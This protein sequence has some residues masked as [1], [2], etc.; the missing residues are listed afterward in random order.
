MKSKQLTFSVASLVLLCV[1]TYCKAGWFTLDPPNSTETELNDIAGDRIDGR[2]KHEDGKYYGC[3]YDGIS[4]TTLCYPGAI[5]TAANGVDGDKIVGMYANTPN[6]AYHGFICDYTNPEEPKWTPIDMDSSMTVVRGIDGVNKVGT[7]WSSG[8]SSGFSYDGSTWEIIP[9]PTGSL[10]GGATDIDSSN[11]VGYYVSSTP[12]SQHGF[13]YDRN[14]V[15]GIITLDFLGAKNT[16][17]TGISGDYVVGGYDDGASEMHGF[18]YNW[19]GGDL[20][21][22]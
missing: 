8:I 18:L 19:L 17:A 16:H 2:I 22:N 7:V 15:A 12:H 1:A 9:Q 4:W 10:Y 14:G 20:G 21:S 5:F 13:I 11:V 3:L 6:G